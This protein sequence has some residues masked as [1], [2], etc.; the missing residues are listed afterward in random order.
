MAETT[1]GKR[2]DGDDGPR[3]ARFAVGAERLVGR[4]ALRCPRVGDA[5]ALEVLE[6]IEPLRERD[7]SGP[8]GDSLES[9]RPRAGQLASL[10]ERNCI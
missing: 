3:C 8:G 6:A 1:F 10:T 4:D 5:C 9:C 7:S 2:R